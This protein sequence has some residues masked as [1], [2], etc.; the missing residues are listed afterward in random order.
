ML[1]QEDSKENKELISENVVDLAFEMRC[2]SLPAD[3]LYALSQAIQQV[4]PWLEDEPLAGVHSI[5]G[6]A[7]GHGWQRP[8]GQGEIMYLSRRTKLMI[9]VPRPRIFDTQTLS[10]Q[11]LDISGNSLKIEGR[12]SEK[13]LKQRPVLFARYVVADANEDEESFLTQSVVALQNLGIRCRK[14][15]C[16]KTRQ[17][18]SAKGQLFSRSLMV[19]DLE[20][21]E[22]IILQEQG[23]GTNKK[24][25]CGLFIPHKG[26][27]AVNERELA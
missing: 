16:G 17:V 11:T 13:A 9:R 21:D 23:L 7:S 19:A 10:G 6:A 27:R 5:H 8:E 20:P 26:I 1:W 25:G 15:L 18:N 2:Q 22:S 14:I 4:L 12:I 24:M 3:H